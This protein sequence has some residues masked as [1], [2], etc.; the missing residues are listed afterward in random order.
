MLVDG[1]ICEDGGGKASIFLGFSNTLEII[2]Q[3]D[4]NI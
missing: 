1:S 4:V 2:V 3:Q